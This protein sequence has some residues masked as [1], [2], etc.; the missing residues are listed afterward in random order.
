MSP[1]IA[2]FKVVWPIL[3][4]LCWLLIIGTT[5]VFLLPRKFTRKWS[6]TK[7]FRRYMRDS[8]VELLRL[9]RKGPFWKYFVV[10][11]LSTNYGNHETRLPTVSRDRVWRNSG[12]QIR[13]VFAATFQTQTF[14]KQIRKHVLV[15]FHNC[16]NVVATS[17]MAP[18]GGLFFLLQY[19]SLVVFVAPSFSKNG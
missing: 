19:R 18:T 4:M 8:F 16:A 5:V 2:L 12:R 15:T 13:T 17:Q 11:R 1:Y 14:T 3:G 9:S 10:K 7:R 6:F